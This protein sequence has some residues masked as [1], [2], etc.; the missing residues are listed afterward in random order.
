MLQA[1]RL[2]LRTLGARCALLHHGYI[3]EVAGDPRAETVE[4]D[5]PATEERVRQVPNPDH[6]AALA[7]GLLPLPGAWRRATLARAVQPKTPPNTGP[8]RPSL[9]S[10]WRPRGANPRTGHRMT[11][12]DGRDMHTLRPLPCL[13]ACA[14]HKA[15]S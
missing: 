1:Q 6:A 4:V 5:D 9:T 10:L 11:Q 15:R 13:F 2:A 8:E 12:K 7:L 3:V 14:R